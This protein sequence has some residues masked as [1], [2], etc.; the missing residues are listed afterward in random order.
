MQPKIDIEKLTESI[1]HDVALAVTDT[2]AAIAD[3]TYDED[4]ALSLAEIID[5]LTTWHAAALAQELTVS[6]SVLVPHVRPIVA[7]VV[8][9][10]IASAPGA[11]VKLVAR[12][13]PLK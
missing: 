11:V 6:P 3:Q 10:A 13:A 2:L 12:V 5:H 4:A 7:A 1:A 9:I 8:D